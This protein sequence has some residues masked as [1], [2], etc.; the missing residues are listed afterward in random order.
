M[1]L[2]CGWPGRASAVEG[3]LRTMYVIDRR[4][5]AGAISIIVIHRVLY[6]LSWFLHEFTPISIILSRIHGESA[7]T[8]PSHSLDIE[9]KLWS[10]RT[11]DYFLYYD[12]QQTKRRPTSGPGAQCIPRRCVHRCWADGLYHEQR[13]SV[14]TP[15][16][17]SANGEHIML[18]QDIP[19]NGLI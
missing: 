19:T 17:N 14:S 7:K 10:S 15:I 6:C 8:C 1:R 3:E 5:K 18:S 13:G 2:L 16:R 9:T 11:V 4:C 12:E